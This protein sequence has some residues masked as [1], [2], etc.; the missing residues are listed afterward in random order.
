M[1]PELE[2]VARSLEV[3]RLPDTWSKASYP[4]K[5]RLGAYLDDLVRRVSMLQVGPLH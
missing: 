3:G 1:S 5:K 4:T 2:S